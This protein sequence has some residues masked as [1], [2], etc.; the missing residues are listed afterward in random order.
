M[1][2]D[3]DRRANAVGLA[4]LEAVAFGCFIG[5]VLLAAFFLA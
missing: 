5:A 3:T 1:S 2:T 4:I